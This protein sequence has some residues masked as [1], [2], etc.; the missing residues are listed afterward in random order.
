MKVLNHSQIQQKI[1]R[2]SFEILENNYNEKEMFLAG[3]NR[4]GLNFAR[5]LLRELKKISDI[6]FVLTNITLNPALPL[7]EAILI[8]TPLAELK[9]K[10]IIIID[11]VANTGRTIYFAMK[12]LMDFVPKKVEAAVLVD[13]THKFFPINVDYVGLSLATTMKENIDVRLD[14]GNMEVHLN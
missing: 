14:K 8:D 7:K 5:L 13:R 9:N 10:P 11:D 4:N 1:R 3:I 12:P 6:D 2:L